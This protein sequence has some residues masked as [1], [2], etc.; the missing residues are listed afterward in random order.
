M[1][2]ILSLKVLAVLF[3]FRLRKLGWG[4]REGGEL[5]FSV[6]KESKRLRRMFGERC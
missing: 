3:S 6:Y 5:K 4:L 1:E 2:H